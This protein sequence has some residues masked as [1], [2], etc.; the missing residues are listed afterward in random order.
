[1]DCPRQRRYEDSLGSCALMRTH[2]Q[3]ALHP[4]AYCVF[5]RPTAA[6]RSPRLSYLLMG[7]SYL[8]DYIF[9]SNDTAFWRRNALF[10]SYS[11]PQ[12]AHNYNSTLEQNKDAALHPFNLSFLLLP[13]S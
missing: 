7:V 13:R 3:L 8:W 9:T 12:R 5:R 4:T 6:D 1:M 2:Q 10:Y 11:H